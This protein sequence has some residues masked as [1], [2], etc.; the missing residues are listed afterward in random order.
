MSSAKRHDRATESSSSPARPESSAGA[1]RA[2]AHSRSKGLPVLCSS[3]S[4]EGTS[5][6]LHMATNGAL[7]A[8]SHATWSAWPVCMC[9]GVCH[10]C[11]VD[12][13]RRKVD[14]DEPAGGRT[15]RRGQGGSTN[16]AHKF[17]DSWSKGAEAGGPERETG[18]L[19]RSQE[20]TL[21]CQACGRAA[22]T[23]LGHKGA[24]ARAR[25]QA[26]GGLH[27]SWR[28]GLRSRYEQRKNAL[29]D[30]VLE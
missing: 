18:A 6:H 13:Q 2:W 5:Q 8:G 19:Q 9:F 27:V 29:G 16:G 11:A 12:P 3:T 10:G 23:E 4:D 14:P 25:G 1:T 22:L 20:A 15:A 28:R 7:G 30:C 24:R 17:V 26:R 21:E